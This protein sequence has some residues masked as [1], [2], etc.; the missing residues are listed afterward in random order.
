MV[1]PY[2]SYGSQSITPFLYSLYNHDE[3]E[4]FP[5]LPSLVVQ[6]SSSPS[7]YRLSPYATTWTSSLT[8]RIRFIEE[9]QSIEVDVHLFSHRQLKLRQLKRAKVP[10]NDMVYVYS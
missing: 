10:T 7:L 9:A 1:R 6:P 3:F 4:N 5:P 2:K 8:C